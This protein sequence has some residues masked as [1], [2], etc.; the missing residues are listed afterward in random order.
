MV[1]VV[2]AGL[3]GIEMR[4][5]NPFG[6]PVTAA[7]SGGPALLEQPMM[8]AAGEGQVTYMLLS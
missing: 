4:R 1:V 5:R 2:G 7:F 6:D 8:R 3:A